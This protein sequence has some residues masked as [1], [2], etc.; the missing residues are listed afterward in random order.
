MAFL[1]STEQVHNLA[2]GFYIELKDSIASTPTQK[3]YPGD[4][5]TVENGEDNENIEERK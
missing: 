1:L 5:M 4:L 2:K 3:N